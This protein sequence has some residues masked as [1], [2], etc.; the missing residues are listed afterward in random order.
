M[1][2]VWVEHPDLDD[3]LHQVEKTR[4]EK[5]MGMRGWRLADAPPAIP[6]PAAEVKP[7]PLEIRRKE[8]AEATAAAAPP[9][10]LEARRKELAKVA[11]APTPTDPLAGRRD[12]LQAAQGKLV[13][14]AKDPFEARRKELA[15]QSAPTVRDFAAERRAEI[16]A[17][18]PVPVPAE[19][20]PKQ[21]TKKK[22]TK[23]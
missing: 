7:D 21:T 17:A 2:M 19:P 20:A 13:E 23:K 18:R 22:S 11:A 14:A 5:S 15:K 3:S 6:T 4:Y 10:P 9:D 12:E 8:L 16:L 1:E